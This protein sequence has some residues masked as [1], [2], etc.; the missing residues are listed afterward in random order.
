VPN[1]Q[2]L[3]GKLEKRLHAAR[4]RVV[5]T[6]LQQAAEP[7]FVRDTSSCAIERHEVSLG[8]FWNEHRLDELPGDLA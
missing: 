8:M 6:P 7:L 1:P 5:Q 4:I 2:L 3:D